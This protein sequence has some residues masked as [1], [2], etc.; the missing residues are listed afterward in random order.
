M[1]NRHRSASF[2]WEEPLLLDE[3]LTNDERMVRESARSCPGRMKNEAT[4]AVEIT[5]ITKRNSCGVLTA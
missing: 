3:A 5:S 1:S 4:A 2:D